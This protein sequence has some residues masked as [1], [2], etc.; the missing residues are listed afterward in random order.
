MNKQ[1]M[2]SIGCIV[3]FSFLAITSLLG[4]EIPEVGTSNQPIPVSA[5]I[6]TS[7]PVEATPAPMSATPAPASSQQPAVQPAPQ[8]VPTPVRTSAING[9]PSTQNA[10]STLLFGVLL[11]VG[12]LSLV[13]R[14][15]VHLSWQRSDNGRFLNQPAL[16]GVQS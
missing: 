11:I 15:A 2:I 4:A 1:R 13:V 12:A 5:P 3:I 14:L 16:E 8:P 7:A 10:R 6:A 9:T